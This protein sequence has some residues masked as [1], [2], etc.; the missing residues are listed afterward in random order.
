MTNEELVEKAK[1]SAIQVLFKF[2]D[3]LNH[4]HEMELAIDCFVEGSRF[5]CKMAMDAMK[6]E[7][8]KTI[9]QVL[10]ENGIY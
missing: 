6:E 4:E 7:Q 9:A 3:R 1:K 5:G 8:K 2:S 10:K